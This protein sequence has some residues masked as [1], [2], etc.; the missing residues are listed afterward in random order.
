MAIYVIRDVLRYL[1]TKAA[2]NGHV[3]RRQATAG[4]LSPAEWELKIGS[5]VEAKNKPVLEAIKEF[6]ENG[7]ETNR[8]LLEQVTLLG[9]VVK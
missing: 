2:K 3:E 1:T 6:I 5:I 7:R 8:L 9:R 4:E